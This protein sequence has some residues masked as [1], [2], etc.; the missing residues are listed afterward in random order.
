MSAWWNSLK[1][2]Y[3]VYKTYSQNLS[4]MLS[5]TN[6]IY[7]FNDLDWSLWALNGMASLWALD[8]TASRIWLLKN[9]DLSPSPQYIPSLL[10]PT[11][12]PKVLNPSPHYLSV[13]VGGGG[14]GVATTTPSRTSASIVV[15]VPSPSTNVAASSDTASCASTVSLSVWVLPITSTT[16]MTGALSVWNTDRK[17][18][19]L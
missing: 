4:R 10:R 7:Y 17:S 11:S 8:G 15:T 5:L 16:L 3:L 12:V 2:C 13:L 19:V 14:V 6:M 9:I 18:V 1:K